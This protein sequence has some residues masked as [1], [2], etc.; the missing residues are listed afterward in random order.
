MGNLTWRLN[1]GIVNILYLVSYNNYS[2]HHIGGLNLAQIM[3]PTD[4]LITDACPDIKDESMKKG[5]LYELVKD[6]IVKFY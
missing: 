2:L 1:F 4:V 5:Q 3:Q 6:S